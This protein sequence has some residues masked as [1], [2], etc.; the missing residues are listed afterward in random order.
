M[1]LLIAPECIQVDMNKEFWP[2]VY[3][4]TLYRGPKNNIHQL[5]K[6][7]GANFAR[8]YFYDD[9]KEVSLLLSADGRHYVRGF[10]VISI[11]TKGGVVLKDI[12]DIKEF[13]LR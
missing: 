10:T 6:K 9:L 13:L 11:H 12:E 5:H 2:F 4:I 7:N 3:F 8:F 1:S